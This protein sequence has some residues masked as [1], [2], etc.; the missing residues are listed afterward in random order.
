MSDS[1][2]SVVQDTDAPERLPR[3]QNAYLRPWKPGQSGNPGGRKNPLKEVQALCRDRS[4]KSARALADI[5]E[6][7]DEDSARR[8]VAADK[9][10]TWAF[11]RPPDYDP[12]S[13]KPSMVVDLS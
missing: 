8:I 13:D 2:V 11:G 1:A 12:A 5:A 10:L 6:D 3:R 4:L 7:P 9:V